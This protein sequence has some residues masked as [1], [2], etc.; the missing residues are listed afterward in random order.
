MCHPNLQVPVL[1][2]KSVA[3]L[4]W[5]ELP[6]TLRQH[7]TYLHVE[8]HNFSLFLFFF[9]FRSLLS[10]PFTTTS[11][12]PPA[13]SPIQ[14]TPPVQLPLALIRPNQVTFELLTR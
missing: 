9:F 1:E 10:M 4:G 8:V 6:R 7:I 3:L 12:L 2:Y 14:A 5:P 11:D 13:A